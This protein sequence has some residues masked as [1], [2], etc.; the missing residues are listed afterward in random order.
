[1]DRP[2]L[3][4]TFALGVG[5]PIALGL[6]ALL[7]GPWLPAVGGACAAYLAWSAWKVVVHYRSSDGDRP[8]VTTATT[9]IIAVIGLVALAGLPWALWELGQALR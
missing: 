2:V 6:A 3:H 4:F 8:G 7:G 1:M 9:I 5:T